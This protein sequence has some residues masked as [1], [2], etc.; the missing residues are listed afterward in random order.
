MPNIPDS[1]GY[2]NKLRQFGTNYS[3]GK[4]FISASAG[5]YNNTNFYF[6]GVGGDA[7]ERTARDGVLAYGA[8]TS[9]VH[10]AATNGTAISN[11]VNIAGYLSE[12]SHGWQ[13]PNWAI[14]GTSVTSTGAGGWFIMATDESYN[15]TWS[16]QSQSS[17]TTWFAGNALGGTNSGYAPVGA[18]C[19]VWEPGG[20]GNDPYIYYGLWQAGKAFA[21]CAWNSRTVRH[22]VQAIGD[23][24]VQR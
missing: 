14:D 1:I 17:F 6:D 24:F 15:G 10:F 13:S 11:L 19:H 8:S 16:G 23:P 22:R 7:W 20:L 9:A 2:I 5:G 12:G 18:V 4:L 3:P 21:I